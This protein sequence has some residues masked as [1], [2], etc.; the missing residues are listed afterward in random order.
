M[1]SH[2]FWE[3][4]H[5]LDKMLF[6][7]REQGNNGMN[8]AQGL[9]WRIGNKTIIS[10]YGKQCYKTVLTAF[11]NSKNKRKP[12]GTADHQLIQ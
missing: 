6:N 12:I 1:T 5:Y 9:F 4:G 3:T 7:S 8:R 2:G 10:E 11:T